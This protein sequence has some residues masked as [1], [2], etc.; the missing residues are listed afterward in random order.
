M[1]VDETINKLVRPLSDAISAFIFFEVEIFGATIPL[2]VVWLMGS[3]VFFTFYFRFSGGVETEEEQFHHRGEHWSFDD[4]S[5]A[6][7]CHRVLPTEAIVPSKV[8]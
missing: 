6:L 7:A 2:I 5:T 8:T 3:A 1:N 4:M